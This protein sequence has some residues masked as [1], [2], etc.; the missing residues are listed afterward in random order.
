MATA[1]SKGIAD[2]TCLQRTATRAVNITK[3]L[4]PWKIRNQ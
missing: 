2:A 1:V 3:G 4:K